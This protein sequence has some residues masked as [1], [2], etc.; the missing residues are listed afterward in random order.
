MTLSIMK[1]AGL[2]AATTLLGACSIGSYGGLSLGSAGYYDDGYYDDGYYGWYD[3]YYYPGTGYY[4]YDRDR[5]AHRWNARQQRYWMARRAAIRDQR[6]IRANWNRW[7]R[8]EARREYRR[9]A[10]R[11]ARR[12][13]RREYRRDAR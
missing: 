3:D 13:Y 1:A 9:D 7:E 12:E 10:R 6:R 11:D 2:A 4:V 8:R 5:R